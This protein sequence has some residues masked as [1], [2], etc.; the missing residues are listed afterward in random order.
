MVRRGNWHAGFRQRF[1]KYNSDLKQALTNRHVLWLHAVSVGEVNL[2]LQLIRA[3]EP[4]LPNIKF[5]V[6]T[7]T[8]TGMAELR[9][10]LP[11]RISKIYYPIDRRKYVNRAIATINPEAVVLIEAEIWPNFIQRLRRLNIPLM[12]VN[13]RISDRS[14]PRYQRF[15]FI[16]RQLFQTFVAV[17]CQN[18]EDARRLA[19]IGCRPEAVEVLGNMKFDAAKTGERIL[20]D[21]RGM[22]ERL[23]VPKDALIVI[24]GSTHDGE[25]VLL[26]D[27]VHRLRSKFPKLF[28]ILVPRHSER[29]R[30]VA[31]KLRER[32][33]AF[34]Y[35]S[36]IDNQTQP[37]EGE[38]ECLLV[39]TTGELPYFYH[40]ADVVFVGKSLT[41]RGGQNPI[42]PAAQGKAIIVGPHMQNFADVVRIFRK[43]QAILQV[44]SAAE[45]EKSLG[46]L[47]ADPARRAELGQNARAVVSEN[48]GALQ[49]TVE[50]ILQ[51]LKPRGI[52]VAD[53]K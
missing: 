1:A 25:E 9:K 17:G 34:I 27:M 32:H 51:H 6:S 47:L 22:L 19:E 36:E 3:L 37:R 45:L 5:V 43:R 10:R 31:K 42:E 53:K 39:N 35:R 13:A 12:L 52:Y 41:A 50:M 16:F 21:V 14:F 46:Q 20:L 7:T 40:V 8:S 29:A 11:P 28:L 26:A 30:E 15:G 23:G 33:V 24:G 4:R 48:S 44:S 2:C 49:H 38:L 18:P